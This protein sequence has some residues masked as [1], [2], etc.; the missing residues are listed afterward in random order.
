MGLG[1]LEDTL[2][3]STK[4]FADEA[5]RSEMNMAVP[6]F[7]EQTNSG[8]KFCFVAENIC[9]LNVEYVAKDANRF[10]C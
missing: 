5:R 3:V 6:S 10:E 1:K 8:S 7:L 9:C 2:L 4:N